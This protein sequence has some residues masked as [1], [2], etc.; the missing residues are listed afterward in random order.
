MLTFKVGFDQPCVAFFY[1]NVKNYNRRIAKRADCKRL[2]TDVCCL[3]FCGF[4]KSG[5]MIKCLIVLIKLIECL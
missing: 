2:E 3:F 5:G 4:F 1:H